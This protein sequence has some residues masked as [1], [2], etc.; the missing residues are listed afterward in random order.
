[1]GISPRTYGVQPLTRDIFANVS[2]QR[3]ARGSVILLLSFLPRG[4]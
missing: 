2:F 3:T 4:R 1:M